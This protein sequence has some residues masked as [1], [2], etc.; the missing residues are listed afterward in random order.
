MSPKPTFVLGV[1]L[2]TLSLPLLANPVTQDCTLKGIPLKGRVQ[3]VDHFP[4]LRVKIVTTFPDLNVKEVKHFPTH[5]GE[6]QFVTAFPD[7]KIQLVDVFPDLTIKLVNA[8]PG[9]N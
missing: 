5:C 9:R 7:F 1:V 6:W 3:I 8:F 2:I 4:D